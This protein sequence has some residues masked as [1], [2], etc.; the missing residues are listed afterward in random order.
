[1]V[2]SRSTLSGRRPSVTAPMIKLGD[3]EVTRIGLGTNRLE[4]TP[5]NVAFIRAAVAAGIDHIDS[6]YL[7][8]G[9]DSETTIGEALAPDADGVLVA[10]KGGFAP[11]TG[12]PEALRELIEES[13]RR[14]QTR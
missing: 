13:L 3:R 12:K 2:T 8:T 5:D 6:A 1:M 7:Y 11:G 9:G 10:T 4:H 14:L